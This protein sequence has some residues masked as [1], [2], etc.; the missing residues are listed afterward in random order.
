M[1]L[2]FSSNFFFPPIF[3][4]VFC[5]SDI[6]SHWTDSLHIIFM[7]T[8]LLVKPA[9]MQPYSYEDVSYLSYVLKIIGIIGKATS[10]IKDQ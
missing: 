3:S 9:E 7:L 2:S 8:V 1:D 5:A 4:C 6:I 10:N